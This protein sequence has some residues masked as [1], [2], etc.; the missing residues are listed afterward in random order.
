MPKTLPNYNI[1]FW[2]LQVSYSPYSSK[3]QSRIYLVEPPFS[4]VW[5]VFVLNI[6]TEWPRWLYCNIDAFG[7]FIYFR[8][9]LH[10]CDDISWFVSVYFMCLFYESTY[11]KD[12]FYQVS[13]IQ[14]QSV[15]QTE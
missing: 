3:R 7:F 15:N 14:F 5:G 4:L 13:Q 11:S 2:I 1:F 6:A 8:V 9:F 12:A 10:Q